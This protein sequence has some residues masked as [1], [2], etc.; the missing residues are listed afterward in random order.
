MTSRLTSP[1]NVIVSLDNL[2]HSFRRDGN[3]KKCLIKTLEENLLRTLEKEN[4]QGI[5]ETIEKSPIFISLTTFSLSIQYGCDN[6][7]LC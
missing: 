4:H 7:A 1:L 6:L 2:L 3:G 5:K